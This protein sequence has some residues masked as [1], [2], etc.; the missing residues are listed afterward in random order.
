[1]RIP[2]LVLLAAA[3][4]AV[5]LAATFGSGASAQAPAQRTLTYKELERGAT[6]AHIRHTR[7][8]SS[9]ANSMGD[10][11]VFTNPLADASG[12]VVGKM[13][14]ECVTTKGARNFLRSRLTCSGVSVLAD[15]TL[16]LQATTVPRVPTTTGAVTG[17]TGAYANA[18]GVFVSHEAR[19]GSDTTITLVD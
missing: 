8:R 12:R 14:V 19:G 2:S 15:G 16:T 10:Q 3:G 6:F 4:G 17:G 1:M 9:Q 13:H 7:T 5:A 11:I 18:R